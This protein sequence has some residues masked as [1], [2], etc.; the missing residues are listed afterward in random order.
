MLSSQGRGLSSRAM[1]ST[2][3]LL[4]ALVASLLLQACEPRPGVAPPAASAPAA[5]SA[6]P[7]GAADDSPAALMA[8]AFSGWT[9][10]AGHAVDVPS[11]EGTRK[12]RVLVSPTLVATL[13]ADHRVLIVSGVPDDGHGQPEAA[14]ATAVNLGLYGFEARAGRWFKTFERPSLAWTGSYGSPGELKVHAFGA[15]RAVLSVQT[16]DCGQGFCGQ[17]LQLFALNP[18]DASELADQRLGGSATDATVGC[19]EWLQG[20][21]LGAAE[22]PDPITPGNCYDVRGEWR[23]EKPVDSAWPDL[24]ITFTGTQASQDPKGGDVTRRIVDEQLVMRH[25]GTRY[26]VLSGRNPAQ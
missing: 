6:Q 14:H 10:Q 11:G 4:P 19:D 23:F 5:S 24:V 8:Q 20:K 21:P 3:R 26:K 22:T 1:K 9:S 7:A 15:G 13:D 25:D 2:A 17:R 12:D 18:R 16:E